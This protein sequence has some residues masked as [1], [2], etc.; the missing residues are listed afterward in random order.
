M[1]NIIWILKYIR[2][3]KL[4]FLLTILLLII[5]SGLYIYAIRL[6]QTLIDS[7]IIEEKYHM[8]V[9]SILFIAICYIAYSVLYVLNPFLQSKIFGFVK[10]KLTH[11]SLNHM[12]QL[13][14]ETI[15]NERT[16]RFVNHLTNEVTT[17]SGIVGYDLLELIRNFSLF[18]ITSI[19]M[20]QASK[21]LFLLLIL[22]SSFYYFFGTYFAKRRKKVMKEIHQEKNELVVFLTES[23][24]SIKD[25][26]MNNNQ[27]WLTNRYTAVFQNFYNSV[28]KDGKLLIKQIITQEFFSSCA[29]ILVLGMG[30]YLI[31]QDQI[32][33]GTLVVIYQLTTELI[34]SLQRCCN[35]AI[36][37][38]GKTA[39]IERVRTQISDQTV[40]CETEDDL[41]HIYQIEFQNVTYC[42][43]GADTPIINNLSLLLPAG[44]KIA[45]VGLSGSGKSTITYLLNCFYQ[46]TSGKIKIN[47]VD[48]NKHTVDSV[49]EKI[50]VVFQDPYIF[51]DTLRNNILMGECIDEQE[52]NKI[53]KLM[54][55]SPIL[56]SLPYGLDTVIG[57][58][59]TTLSG[60]EKQRIALARALIRN[61]EVLILDEATSALDNSMEKNVQKNIDYIRKGKTTIIIAHRLSTIK[62]SDMICVLNNGQ[63]MNIDSHQGLLNNSNLY[64][65]LISAETAS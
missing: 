33:I 30:A 55:I 11:Q 5:E 34:N 44:K 22:L 20:I 3:N 59:G 14:I 64:R 13:P 51:N 28:L 1:D 10:E 54:Y 53:C 57:E 48:I 60:G 2:V 8:L 62:N 37:L 17:A 24:S 56:N 23:V 39:V 31:F 35:G 7:V 43:K 19:F 26:I 58:R 4:L 65:K 47:N 16:G 36:E 27:K 61:S 45:F 40:E 18:T 46:P 15:E 38:Y 32:T 52:L 9:T 6:Q 49:R 63:I 50:N 25:V 21:W 12:T 42:Y 41:V 29:Y